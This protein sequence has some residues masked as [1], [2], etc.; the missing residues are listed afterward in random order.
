M[1][2][3]PGCAGAVR[4]LRRGRAG[5]G[6]LPEYFSASARTCATSTSPT[7]TTA[8]LPGWYHW[9]WKARTS[10]GVIASRGLIPPPTGRGGGGRGVEGGGK[11]LLD[12]QGAGLVFGA[13]AALFLDD[14]DLFAEL[15]VGPVV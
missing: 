5:A 12:Q 2:R 7:T 14:L 4:G 6:R 8:A 15:C 10:S 9:R 1:R 3:R 11:E 13:Q